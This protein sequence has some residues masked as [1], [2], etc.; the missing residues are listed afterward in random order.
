MITKLLGFLGG[1]KITIFVII[2]LSASVISIG[3]LLKNAYQANGSYKITIES[4]SNL[5]EQW[6][7]AN[8]LSIQAL[9]NQKLK[10]EAAEKRLI[11]AAVKY[12]ELKGSTNELREKIKTIENDNLDSDLGDDFWLHIQASATNASTISGMSGN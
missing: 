3:W 4:Q 11:I 2:A 5:I 1:N 10:H 7:A 6:Q 12:K 8:D 9:N